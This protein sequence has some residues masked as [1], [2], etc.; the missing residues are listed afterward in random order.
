MIAVFPD[1]GIT[2]IETIIAVSILT[3][4]I[5]GVL[6]AFPLGVHLAKAAQMSTV[7]TQLSQAKIEE[8]VSHSYTDIPV[9]SSQEDYGQIPGFASYKR[10]TQIICVRASDLS[11]VACDYDLANDPYPMKRIEVTVY[12]RSSLGVT[13]KNISLMSLIAKK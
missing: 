9:G 4:G 3:L 12:W 8:E 11:Q 13:E 7:A 5:I 2:L 10:A 6:Q 1:K